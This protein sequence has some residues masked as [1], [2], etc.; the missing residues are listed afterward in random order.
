[1]A[2]RDSWGAWE[3][4]VMPRKRAG[5]VFEE[6]AELVAMLP[7]W[8]GIGLAIA[9][10]ATLG[11]FAEPAKMAQGIRPAQ[12]VFRAAAAAGQYIVPLVCLFGAAVSAWRRVQRRKLARDATENRAANAL[13][14]MSWREFEMLVGEAFRMKG[15]R[16]LETGGGGPDGGVD[17]VLRKGGETFLVQCKQWK[18]FKVGVDVVRQLYGVM[19]AR[20]ATGGFVVT[21]GRFTDEARSFAGGRN[22]TLMDGPRLAV[23]LESARR[24]R[25]VAGRRAV[26]VD[27]ATSASATP[28]CPSCGSP[29]MRRTARRGPNAGSAFWG[30]STY[31]TCKGTRAVGPDE[32]RLEEAPSG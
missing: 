31:P 3:G 2:M 15:F 27:Q 1:M 7:W 5:S 32:R 19:A 24:A 16:V 4:N 20:G 23:M 22:V 10:Y 30:C 8:L 9:A 6:L 17:L 11:S 14:G 28:A 25:E 13:H 21:S 12:A 18:A 26:Q 29:M